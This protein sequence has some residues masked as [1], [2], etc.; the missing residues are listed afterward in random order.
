MSTPFDSQCL[1]PSA[2]ANVTKNYIREPAAEFLGVMILVMFGNGAACQAQ[3]S[4]NKN[5]ASTAYGLKT[6][7]TDRSQDALSINFGFAVGLGLGGWLAGLTSKG[8]INP[9]VTIAMATFRPKDF[10]WRKVPGY[11]LGQVL[12]GL[13]GAGIVYA[14]Y[15]HAIDLV[16]GGRHIRTVPGTASL[17]GTYALP[18]MTSA[19]AWFEEFLG[20][21]LLLIAI[22]A[23]SNT[24]D[25]PTPPWLASLVL[26]ITMLGISS[27]FGMQTGFA[28]NPA[29]D[30]GPRLLTA[31]VGYGDQVFTFRSHY[32]LW[33]PVL[34]P[35]VGALVGT[36]FYDLLFYNGVDSILTRPSDTCAPTKLDEQADIS[37]LKHVPSGDEMA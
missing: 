29:R 1:S 30:L 16:E 18:Y 12:G 33:C 8:H 20:T 5:V 11:I 10:P 21:A 28:I 37:D 19:S 14:N 4:G 7:T 13:C 25:A 3:L 23:M 34:A 22:C 24:K 32:W 15:I 26:F 35:I 9:A 36:F 17:F 2:N 6:R 31:M 27:S